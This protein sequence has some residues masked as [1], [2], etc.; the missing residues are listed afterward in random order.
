[1]PVVGIVV[2]LQQ[3]RTKRLVFVRFIV[4]VHI[5]LS[6]LELAQGNRMKILSRFFALQIILHVSST[7]RMNRQAN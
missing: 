6:L 3:I 2:D 4:T 5:H 1:M 7:C